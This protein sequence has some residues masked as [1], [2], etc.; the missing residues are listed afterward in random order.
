M[1]RAPL[2]S[3]EGFRKAL[4][5][6]PGLQL[7]IAEVHRVHRAHPLLVEPVNLRDRGLAAWLGARKHL[8]GRDRLVLGLLDSRPCKF[9]RWRVGQRGIAEHLANRGQRIALVENR[10]IAVVT[11]RMAFLA[12]DSRARGM[13]GADPRDARAVVAANKGRK[14]A[15]RI[16][17]PTRS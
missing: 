3:L 16:L 8:V 13:K 4:E 6:Q 2:P 11:E 1:R 9:E 14:N 12:Q 17:L 15:T 5:Q 7:Q 10:K